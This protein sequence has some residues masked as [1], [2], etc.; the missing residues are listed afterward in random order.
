M[1]TQQKPSK[2]LWLQTVR[3]SIISNTVFWKC[4]RRP[5]RY[6]YVN[7]LVDLDFLLSST[8]KFQKMHWRTITQKEN[9]ESGQMTTFYSSNFSALFVIFI[10]EFKSTQN[11]FSS[12]IWYVE[13]LNIWPKATDSESWSYLSRMQ[14]PC[15]G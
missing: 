7:G 4:V 9:M 1:L 11:L 3:Q 2:I 6:I 13:Y 10:S 12:A 15:W 14:T 8:Q 5:F